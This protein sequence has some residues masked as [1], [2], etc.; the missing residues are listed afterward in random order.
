MGKEKVRVRRGLPGIEIPAG[1]RG[2]EGRATGATQQGGEERFGVELR[3]SWN[4][5]QLSAV[6]IR[7]RHGVEANQVEHQ[8]LAPVVSLEEGA[9]DGGIAV[10]A[11]R[12]LRCSRHKGVDLGRGQ[13]PPPAIE[14]ETEGAIED[15]RGSYQ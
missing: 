5:C 12:R 7:H 6:R 2:D 1:R 15:Q 9:D 11:R 4:R 14:P 10:L 8:E 3:Q 13:G